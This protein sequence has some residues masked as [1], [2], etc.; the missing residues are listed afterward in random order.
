MPGGLWQGCWETEA[1]LLRAAVDATYLGAV[2]AVYAHMQP[3]WAAAVMPW[4][5]MAA[6]AFTAAMHTLLEGVHRGTDTSVGR[7]CSPLLVQP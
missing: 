3:T 7:V 1:P 6:A 5:G 2:G 4:Q